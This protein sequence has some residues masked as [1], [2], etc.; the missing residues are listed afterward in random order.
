MYSSR[1]KYSCIRGKPFIV[2]KLNK[3]HILFFL[4]L[5]FCITNTHAQKEKINW[6]SFEQLDDSLAVKSKKVFIYF[7]AD[8]CTYCK[9]IEQSAFK[10]SEVISQLN[11]EFY[12]VKMNAETGKE[13]VFEGKKFINE[14]LGKSR[15]PTHQIPLLLASRK[16][17]PFSLPAMIILDENFKV[18]KRYFEYLSPKKMIDVLTY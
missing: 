18:T 17:R 7:Y 10:N 16:N 2:M 3:T 9:K 5:S 6:I 4:F 12:A 1:I 8:W 11:K 14:Q 13:I 15:K